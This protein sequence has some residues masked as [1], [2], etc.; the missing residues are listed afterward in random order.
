MLV[1]DP[2]SPLVKAFIWTA[3]DK[4]M[5]PDDSDDETILRYVSAVT[6][7][8]LGGE[9]WTNQNNFLS[10]EDLCDW[11]DAQQS[12]IICENGEEIRELQLCK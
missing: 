1:E 7:Y 2:N 8:S 5:R 12:G 6:Y 9:S 10:Q 11:N 3:N 4:A